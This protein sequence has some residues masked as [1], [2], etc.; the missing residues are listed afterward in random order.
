LNWVAIANTAAGL[1][2]EVERATALLHRTRLVSELHIATRPGDS[3]RLAREAA[4]ADGLVVL[5]GDGTVLQVMNA[6]D[7]TRQRLAVIPCGH[8][9]CL[10][11]DLRLAEVEPAIAALRTGHTLRIDLMHVRVTAEGQAP[12]ELFAASTLAAGYV[13]D[14]VIFGRTRLAALGRHAYAAASVATRPRP[15]RVRVQTAVASNALAALTGVVV[16]NTAHLANFRAFPSARLD[17]G[18]LDVMEQSH[19]WWRQILHN[20][21]ILVGSSRFGPTRLTQTTTVT[22]CFDEPEYLM[23]DGEMLQGVRRVDV[24]CEPRAL[25]CVCAEDRRP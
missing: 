15:C 5:G 25:T 12:C 13:A 4:A 23:L 17:D 3:A 6:M 22:L 11:R 16:N 7:L 19:G 14:T 8:G 1:K 18:R 9:N 2:G 10:A 21:A 20:A 24:R